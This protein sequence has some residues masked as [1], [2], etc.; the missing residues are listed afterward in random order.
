[1]VILATIANLQ[2]GNKFCMAICSLRYTMA[3]YGRRPEFKN[4]VF[5]T[6]VRQRTKSKK[7]KKDRK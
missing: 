2:I 7:K 3:E 1:L 6:K 5:V 4:A